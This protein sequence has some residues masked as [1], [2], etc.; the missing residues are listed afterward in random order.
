MTTFTWKIEQLE[1][2][3]SDG[4]VVVSYWRV[5]AVDGDYTA[6]SYGSTTHSR[7]DEFTPYEDLAEADVINWVK[8]K[9]DVAEIEAS[10]QSQIDAKRTPTQLIGM[11]WAVN[12]SQA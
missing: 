9:L 7:A 4:L 12:E 8:A 1:R 11:P 2:Q 10:L 5:I 6:E 3:A